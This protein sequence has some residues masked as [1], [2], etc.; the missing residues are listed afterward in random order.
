MTSSESS[1]PE[2][3]ESPEDQLA[4]LI[5]YFHGNTEGRNA[6]MARETQEEVELLTQIFLDD[7]ESHEKKKN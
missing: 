3:G 1:V 2:I 4:Q 6:E 5:S 7:T